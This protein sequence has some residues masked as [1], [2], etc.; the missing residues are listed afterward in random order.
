MFKGGKSNVSDGNT[1]LESMTN[2]SECFKKEKLKGAL[3]KCVR[4]NWKY[5]QS[6]YEADSGTDGRGKNHWTSCRE[7]RGK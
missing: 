4:E 1:L 6:G 3:R 7:T 5:R 2:D